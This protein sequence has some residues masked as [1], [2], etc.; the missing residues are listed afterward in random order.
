MANPTLRFITPELQTN[1]DGAPPQLNMSRDK[2]DVDGKSAVTVSRG[3][4][5]NVL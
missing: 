5:G 1:C 3:L 4:V 2:R